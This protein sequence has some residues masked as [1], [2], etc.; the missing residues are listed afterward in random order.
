MATEVVNIDLSVGTNTVRSVLWGS[1][2]K[3][4][5]NIEYRDIDLTLNGSG[6][7]ADASSFGKKTVTA[8]APA[9]IAFPSGSAVLTRYQNIITNSAWRVREMA[10]GT[11]PETLAISSISGKVVLVAGTTGVIGGDGS[12]GIT[13]DGAGL[14]ATVEYAVYYSNGA[15]GSTNTTFTVDHP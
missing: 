2:Y 8:P 4:G 12:I 15:D 5:V 10:G 7:D 1:I 6:I 3:P 11:H 13:Y 9:G 14:D